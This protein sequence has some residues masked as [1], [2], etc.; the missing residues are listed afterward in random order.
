M[1]SNYGKKFKDEIINRD[2]I[3]LIGVYDVFSASIAA[4]HFD[5][6]FVSGFSFA[7]SFY[8]LPD[9][10]FISWSDLVAFV[11]RLRSILPKH[12]LLVDIDDGY[13]DNEVACQVVSLLEGLGASG[14]ILEDQKRP[15]KCGHLNGKQ[16]MDLDDYLEKL[17]RV[18]ETRKD[19]V[20]IARTD[21]S[22]FD[23]IIKRVKAFDKTDADVILVDG[24]KDLEFIK[25]IK[26]EV[27]KPIVFNQI[28][29][30]KS[31]P[32]NLHELKK[33]GISLALFSTPCL[34]AAQEGIER[35]MLSIKEN[36]GLIQSENSV[37]LKKC[38]AVLDGNLKR[39]IW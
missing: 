10:G 25:K 19:M 17:T 34:F 7:A 33:A 22:E 24:M 38:A 2:I 18:L 21:S 20:V 35:E 12:N 32:L 6:L 8:G 29:G 15:R 9:I 16:I 39:E 27:T 30:G 3:P 5:S 37:D 1:D 36:D 23:D 11:Q 4:R 26:N 14:V 13:A 31:A 28:V